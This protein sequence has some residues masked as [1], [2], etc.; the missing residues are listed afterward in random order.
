V[1]CLSVF[2]S[3][4]LVLPSPAA[5]STGS[6]FG[7]FD[8]TFVGP[9]GVHAVGW[10]TDPDSPDAVQVHIYVDD[11]Y[12][13]SGAA[14]RGYPGTSGTGFFLTVPIPPGTHYVCAYALSIGPGD[15]TLL[16][17]LVATRPPDPFGNV[18][19]LKMLDAGPTVQGWAL[20][21]DTF[22]PIHVHVYVDGS[23]AGQGIADNF[24]IDVDAVYPAFGFTNN[25]R[26]A[27][28][29]RLSAGT[30][31]EVCAYGINVGAGANALLR[32]QTFSLGQTPIGALDIAVNTLTNDVH[33]HGWAIDPETNDPIEVRFYADGA[34]T[35]TLTADRR[36]PELV[37]QFH[38]GD[39][40]GYAGAIPVP[41]NASTLCAYA[42]NTGAGGTNQFLGCQPIE[43]SGN[44]MVGGF[45]VYPGHQGCGD[46]AV[47]V[48][49]WALDPDTTH[50]LRI[51]VYQRQPDD[52]L[53]IFGNFDASGKDDDIVSYFPEYSAQEGY[54]F[55]ACS[56]SNNFYALNADGTPGDSVLIAVGP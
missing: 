9:D 26:F 49:F 18:D 40:H 2:V 29:I 53:Q 42:I 24:S 35:A 15:N 27:I 55:T 19:T 14:D 28:P 46:D 21:T 4:S 13:G 32:C 33:V 30:P 23:F 50:H 11:V 6:P 5:A 54:M 16:G 36:R 52:S 39:H 44:P 34:F 25:H 22:D 7:S 8:Q 20:D 10:A 31:H 41:A 56:H 37:D 17:C 45:Y 51:A 12:A 3:V 38:T 47:S 48:K 1:V 43:R